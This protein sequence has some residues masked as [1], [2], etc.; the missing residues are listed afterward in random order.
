MIDTWSPVGGTVWEG[1]DGG[2]GPWGTGFE[3][4]KAKVIL[5]WLSLLLACELLATAPALFL[6]AC[7]HTPLHDGHD[8]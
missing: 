6:P 4:S 3:V 5:S 1:S 2:S 7:C 8:L